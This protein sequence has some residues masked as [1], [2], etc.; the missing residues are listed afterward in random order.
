MNLLSAASLFGSGLDPALAYIGPGAGFGLFSSFLVVIAAFG[1]ALASFLVWPVR[2]VIALIRGLKRSGKARVRRLIIVGLDG[3]SHGLTAR[4]LED[5]RLPNLAR[6]RDKGHFGPLETTNP[7]I[8]PVAWSTFQT[9]TDPGGHAIFDFLSR[10]PA[11]YMPQLSS[12]R[13]GK[14]KRFLKIGRWTIPLERSPARLLRRSK[15]FWSILGEHGVFSSILRVP[16][17]FPP[18]R[19]NGH[20]LSAMCAPDLMGTQGTFIYYTTCDDA[21]E[22]PGGKV[23]KV[24]KNDGVIRGSVPGP[25]NPLS[26]D[27]A[28]LS[29]M[30]TFRPDGNGGGELDIA[31]A[32]AQLKAGE[33]SDWTRVI[34]HAAPGV[35]IS[36]ICRFLLKSAG[37]D[38]SLYSTALHIDPAKPALPISHPAY[39]SIYLAKL[40]GPFATLGLAED[41]WALNDGILD[42]RQF[43]DLCRLIHTEREK[44]F[45]N[46]LDRQRAGVIACVFD[47]TDRAQH[48]F[49]PGEGPV[50][51]AY[52]AADALIGKTM[53][54][55][56]K[57][58]ELIVLSDH[59]FTEFR[60][61]VSLNSWLMSEG[62]LCLKGGAQRCGSYFADADWTRSS[63]YALGMNGVFLNV[64]G[65]ES[66]GIVEPEK[67][68]ALAEEIAVKLRALSDPSTGERAVA[69]V[70]KADDI[71]HGPYAGEGPDLV[72]GFNAGYR[73]EW[74]SVTGKFDGRVFSDN[75]L[76]WRGDHCVEPSLVPG[77]F[78]S[79]MKPSGGRQRMIDMAPSILELFG[80]P[81]PGYMK[82]RPLFSPADFEGAT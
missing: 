10:D 71:F 62:Y 51:E 4:M 16:I 40:L 18:E 41:T 29:A 56:R 45:F 54:M 13:I 74:E 76:A 50:E 43:L 28:E 1:L 81:I 19:F 59:G 60:R 23:V 9:G 66:Q 78:F 70:H 55:M 65:R 67:A 33:F 47:I 75:E 72:V 79:S 17:T 69:N 7:P 31:G 49:P 26:A 44:M 37:P 38:F 39:Y 11:S 48:M 36:G 52:A 3:M 82:G 21:G 35:S 8:S 61:C 14:P 30:L 6:L 2:L 22:L 20:L 64:R 15:P 53:E 58:D 24:E 73:V 46:A 77:V 63:A 12:A 57:G 68:A 5:G 42:E 80:V 27:G 34:F 25:A 32:V